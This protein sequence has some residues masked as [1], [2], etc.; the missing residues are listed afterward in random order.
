V[1]KGTI[2]EQAQIAR[3][4]ELRL[5]VDSPEKIKIITDDADS[6]A[7]AEEI[8]GILLKE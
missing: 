4:V 8:W 7:Y 3:A 1:S 2:F 6:A 5:G